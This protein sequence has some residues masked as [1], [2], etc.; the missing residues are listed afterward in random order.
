MLPITMMF[1]LV[2]EGAAGD[3]AVPRG[4]MCWG[5]KNSDRAHFYVDQYYHT[6]I[7]W[8]TE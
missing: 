2:L 7:Y 6:L 8:H 5:S 1:V 4:A 3:T